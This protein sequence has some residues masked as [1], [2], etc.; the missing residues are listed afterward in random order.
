ML[1]GEPGGK[2]S[3]SKSANMSSALPKLVRTGE[4][5]QELSSDSAD[6]ESR[7]FPAKSMGPYKPAIRPKSAERNENEKRILTEITS[8][9]G[10]VI[11]TMKLTIQQM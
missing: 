2:K 5:G 4:K 3:E 11:N 6:R 1:C 10:L 8:E 9:F 7:L